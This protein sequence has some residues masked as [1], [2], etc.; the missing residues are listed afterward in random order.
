MERR[1]KKTRE[2]KGRDEMANV[3]I[4]RKKRSEEEETE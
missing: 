3:E 2:E 1:K 4:R